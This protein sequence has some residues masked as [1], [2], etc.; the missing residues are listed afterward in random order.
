MYFYCLCMFSHVASK[1]RD[2]AVSFLDKEVKVLR[3]VC[4]GFAEGCILPEQSRTGSVP[5]LYSSPGNAM[6]NAILWSCVTLTQRKRGNKF[7]GF[8]ECF[9]FTS[10]ADLH[11]YL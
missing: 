8:A 7:S 6:G 1:N 10:E 9:S 2:K 5:C 4:S 3:A 11:I